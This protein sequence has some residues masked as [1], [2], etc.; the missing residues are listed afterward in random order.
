MQASGERRH[1]LHTRLRICMPNHYEN[2]ITL[3]LQDESEKAKKT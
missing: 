2:I 3:V 1:V